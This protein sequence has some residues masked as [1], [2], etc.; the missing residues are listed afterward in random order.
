[1][2][3][4]LLAAALLGACSLGTDPVPPRVV[5]AELTMPMPLVRRL[6]LVLDQ[7]AAATVEYWAEDGPRLRVS[8]EVGTR[9][10]L[11]LTRLRPARHYQYHVLATP[12]TGEFTTEPL[13][14]DLAAVGLS[15]TGTTTAPLVMLHLYDPAGFKGYAIVDGAGEVVWYW[16]TVD[17]PFGATRRENGNFVFMDK[18]RGLVEVSPDGS[19]LHEL[20]QDP[21]QEMHHDVITSLRNTLLFIAFDAR[22]VDEE[23]V[24]GDAIWEWDPEAGTATKR[25]SAWDHF[26]LASDRGPFTGAEWMHA[27]SLAIGP[28]GNVLLSVHHWNQ[29]I[30]IATDWQG[31]EWRLGGPNSTIALPAEL[32]FSGQHTA[33]EVAPG[34]ILL[35]DNRRGLDASSRALMLDFTGETAHER[36]Q[37]APTPPNHASALGSARLLDNGHVVVDF[38]LAVGVENSTG[39]VEVYEV[40]Q[41]G[42]VVWHL[43]VGHTFGMYRAEPLPTVAGE[44]VVP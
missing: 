27:N 8:A 18:G 3:A 38:G 33:R 14:G 30:S 17:L 13:P 11:L 44:Q 36:W 34:R 24:L 31:V 23:R 40:T 1:M 25:W 15:A 20:A 42:A 2:P 5:S 26:S 28:R 19:V 16:R 4:E 6:E 22:T 29:I 21:E 43:V 9:P 39:P 10:A 12:T 41:T 32:R 7:P 37:W 35:F